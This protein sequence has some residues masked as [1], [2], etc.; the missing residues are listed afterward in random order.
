MELSLLESIE[1]ELNKQA[2]LCNHQDCARE[3]NLIMTTFNVMS[4]I[5]TTIRT[6]GYDFL[7]EA[8]VITFCLQLELL[9]MFSK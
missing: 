1:R 5:I 3:I 4:L 8:R 9:F 6:R 2:P 7:S